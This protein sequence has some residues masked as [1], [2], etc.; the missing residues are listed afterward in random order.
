MNKTEISSKQMEATIALFLTGSSL[1]STGASDAKQDTWIAVLLAFALSVPLIWV[2]SEILKLYPGR[3]YFGNILR[4]LG[5]PVGKIVCALLLLFF[6]HLGALVLRV[7]SEFMHIVN[8][9]DTPLIALSAVVTAVGVYVMSNRLYVLARISKFT[10]PFLLVSVALTVLLSLKNMDLNNL[11]PILHSGWPN[12]AKG[13]LTLL[14]VAYGETVICAPMFGELDRKEDVFPVFFKG[15]LWGFAVL[16]V[17]DL[18]NLL[19]LG[20]SAGTYAFPSYESVSIVKLGDFFTRIEVLIGINLLLAGFIKT[21]V[22]LFTACK[23][24]AEMFHFEDYEPLVGPCA[25]LIL[26]LSELVHSN[27]EELFGWTQY[28][29]YYSIPFQILLPVLVLAVGK[30]R[31][32]LQKPGKAER[33]P[34]PPAPQET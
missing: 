28:F 20:Y 13:T 9:T 24:L 7:F 19:V 23:G 31:K 33:Q 12:L 32:K 26:T 22:V 15:A 29:T 6:F 21:V 18:R 16:F 4:A 11:R 5:G 30:I 25:L 14:A 27:M 8:M 2:H 1:I 34:P 10:F 17:A 3:N